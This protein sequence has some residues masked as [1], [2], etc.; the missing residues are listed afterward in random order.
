MLA[1]KFLKHITEILEDK[2]LWGKPSL[3]YI[4]SINSIIIIQTKTFTF[5]STL[6]FQKEFLKVE[7]STT[8]P[9]KKK[10]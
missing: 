7:T 10:E 8:S 6:T 4:I 9:K 3:K 1:S 2:A 5:D